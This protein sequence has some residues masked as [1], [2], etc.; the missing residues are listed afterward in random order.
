MLLDIIIHWKIL[1]TI[2]VTE[3]Y[4]FELAI[5]VSTYLRKFHCLRYYYT[6][7]YRLKE[8]VTINFQ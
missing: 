5:C 7:Y 2:Y 8:S 6:N 3:V 1:E 4:N